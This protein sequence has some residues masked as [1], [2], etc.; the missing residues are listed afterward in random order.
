M[1]KRPP[2]V[3]GRFY[4]GDAASLKKTI[5][6]FLV[7]GMI[8]GPAVSIIAPH[9]G[10]I[11]SGAVAG[12]VYSAVKIPDTV[13]LIGPNH[14]GL[15]EQ[16][17]VMDSGVWEIPTGTVEVNA[18]ISD[19]ILESD[20]FTADKAAHMMEHSLEVQLPFIK[21]RNAKTTI[22]PITVMHA[23]SS[24]CAA[25]GEALADAI[26]KY[27]K[28]VLII[29]SSDMN[30]YESDSRTR[31]KDKIALER[32]LKLDADGLLRVTRNKDITMCG[33]IPASIAINASRLLG[34]KEA[35]LV[36]YATSGETSGD[37]QQVVGYAGVVIQ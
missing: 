28:P 17:S 4:P 22:V 11:Y 7:P 6:S 21:A 20:L 36:K 26:K 2:C 1:A 30:H 9:A 33:V 3:A 27:E 10:Y 34:A 23:D 32:V 8:A 24:L 13:V 5:D 29:V 12:A 15:G 37:F 35:T 18:E 31:E 14:T 16:V 25:L 19:L